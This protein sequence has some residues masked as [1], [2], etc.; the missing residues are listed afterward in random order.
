MPWNILRKFGY[1]P[2]FI[3]IQQ[4]F[5]S[6]MCAE[7]VIAGSQS[8]NL[9]VDVRAKQGCVLAPII[10]KLFIVAMTLV[11]LRDFQPFDSV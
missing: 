1:P 11:S 9:P 8:S 2:T 7:V 5:H 3:A 4:K 10:F 6:A